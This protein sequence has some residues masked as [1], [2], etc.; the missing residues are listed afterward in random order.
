M[1]IT[2][3]PQ[4]IPATSIAQSS[5][6]NLPQYV[7]ITGSGR[8]GTTWLGQIMNMYQNCIYKYEPFLNS[9]QTPYTVWKNNLN[10]DDIE[11]LR[12]DFW[13]LCCSCYYGVDVPPFPPKSFRTQNKE[14][15]HF[16][17]GL[18]KRVNLSK[19]L[20]QWYGRPQLTQ[21]TSVLIK[22][23]NFPIQMLP[24]LCE[25][26]QP[27]L[28]T[29]VRNPFANIAS[30]L[31]GVEMNLFSQEFTQQVNK[32]EQQLATSQDKHLSQ[33]CQQL[34][35]MSVAQLAAVRWRFQVEPLVDY[36]RNH[37]K[38]L[39][40]V[41]EDL[42][43]DPHR[44]IT[45]IFNFVG[46]QFQQTVHDFIDLSTAGETQNSQASKAYYSV[47][48]DPK[49]SM[50]KWKTQLTKEQQSDIASIIVDS[51]L[52]NLWSDLPF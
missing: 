38:G 42:C 19:N 50:S 41:Y 27:H 7:L 2:I 40:V 43:T 13:S 23:V 26:L 10:S 51:P 49:Q 15:L 29:L 30:Y 37:E 31:K 33:Y 4:N 14:I 32:L 21:D 48:R 45:E 44:Q 24:R 39:L 9:K 16:L 47:Y 52:K 22:D 18:G 20:Y 36:A 28:I 3:Q 5:I 8:S 35:N 12:H 46:W 1:S 34:K 17:Y 25:V 6:N 11:Q